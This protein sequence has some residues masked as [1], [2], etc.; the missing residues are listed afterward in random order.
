ML[1]TRL[2][3][4]EIHHVHESDLQVRKIVSQ[5]GSS[6]QSFQR[7]DIAGCG[8]HHVWFYSLVVARPVPNP[9][10][11]RT[12]SDRRFRVQILEVELL[13]RNDY[14]DVVP[15]PKTMISDGE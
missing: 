9:D 2:K 13:I 8:N 1:R 15:A 3:L 10:P 7:R 11:F 6:G 4:K 5:Q 14:V 12:M